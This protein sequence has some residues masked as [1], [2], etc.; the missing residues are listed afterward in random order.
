MFENEVN[1]EI[2]KTKSKIKV[3]IFISLVIITIAISY[4]KREYV[5]LVLD[6]LRGNDVFTSIDYNDVSEK[7]PTEIDKQ[8]L[9]Y[10]TIYVEDIRAEAK[11]N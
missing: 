7:Y 8:A 9:D 3:L 5:F 1:N 4:K 2:H 11:K 10:H 6:T